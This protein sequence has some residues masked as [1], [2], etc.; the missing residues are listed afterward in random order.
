VVVGREAQPVVGRV[1]RRRLKEVGNG[2]VRHFLDFRQTL[3]S[4]LRKGVIDVW[5]Q[6]NVCKR[7]KMMDYS[8]GDDGLLRRRAV[9]LP[10]RVAAAVLS[11]G[12]HCQGRWSPLPE[13]ISRVMDGC[14]GRWWRE[15]AGQGRTG[16]AARRFRLRRPLVAHNLLG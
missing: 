5:D 12:F 11:A 16:I 9:V 3:P 2:A 6:G 10:I 4:A 14:F 7:G 8:G 15:E 13:G 1:V